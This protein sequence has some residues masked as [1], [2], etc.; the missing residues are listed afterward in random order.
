MGRILKMRRLLI[1]LNNI[2]VPEVPEYPTLPNMPGIP[3]WPDGEY[4]TTT[5]IFYT[6]NDSGVTP[7]S[8]TAF[9]STII[10]NTFNSS[11]NMYVLEFDGDV[12]S[13]GSNAFRNR[14]ALCNV[15]LPNS[16]T[17]IGDR[18]FYYCSDLDSI[19]TGENITTIGASSFSTCNLTA[20]SLGPKLT[21]IGQYA[22]YG[23][24]S[25]ALVYCMAT[26]PPKGSYGMFEGI[27]ENC[28]IHVPM[29]SVDSY[30]SAS[31]W[32]NYADMIIGYN[33]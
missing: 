9:G 29:S 15:V 27:N 12:N 13:V 11:Y 19:N 31:Y 3:A 18:A 23:C 22:F 2:G 26:T 10:S 17:S 28:K 20:I 5:K 14:S 25:L 8:S 6:S 7:Y 16:V 21:T 33:F 4:S 30:K 24:E 1:A 32:S